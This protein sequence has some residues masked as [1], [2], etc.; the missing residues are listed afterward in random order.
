[1]Q[2][3][4]IKE[5]EKLSNLLA[6]VEVTYTPLISIEDR[7]R[8]TNSRTS[9]DY[10]RSVWDAGKLEYLEQFKVLFL[11]NANHI[12]GW[13]LISSGGIC[14]TMADPRVIFQA[15]LLSNAAAIILVHNHPSGNRTPSAADLNLTKRLKAGGELI[16]IKVLDHII[17]TGV[18][19]YSFADEGII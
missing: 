3:K 14:G 7:T 8:I 17:L 4:D 19:Y 9:A 2:L 1:M 13:V 5:I 16:D 10:A 15:A 18:S 6:E 11:N 12:I